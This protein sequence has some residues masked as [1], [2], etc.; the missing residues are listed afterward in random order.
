M[1]AVYLKK[2]VENILPPFLV[3]IMRPIYRRFSK[4]RLE[5]APLGWD[6]KFRKNTET[7][8]NSNKIS[9]TEKIKWEAFCRNSSG[10]GPLGFAHESDDLSIVRNINFHNIHIT[11]AYV[12]A[13]TAHNKDRIS[14][15]DW[16]G[17]LG[18]YYQIARAVLPEVNLDYHCKEVEFMVKV[19]RVVNPDIHWHA[20]ESYLNREYDLVMVSSSL[21]YV[22]DWQGLLIDLIG[23]SKKYFFLTRIP[24]VQVAA[25][26]VAIQRA[27]G[28]ELLC[29]Q[30]NQNTLLEFVKARDLDLVREFVVEDPLYIKHAPEA[31]ELR[32]WLFKKK[33]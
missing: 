2:F 22:K 17:A 8:W 30:F 11:Y 20:D 24:V 4:S 12:L 7:G 29:H 5:Y 9:E 1:K 28:E 10:N 14:V 15:L 27:Y 32:G 19:G 21:Q 33:D 25:S 16:G 6:T 18:H 13:L 3:K 31:C 23:I 26:F